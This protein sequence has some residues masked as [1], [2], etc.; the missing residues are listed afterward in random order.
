LSFTASVR[1]CRTLRVLL[2][3][4]PFQKRMTYPSSSYLEGLIKTIRNFLNA[5]SGAGS[6]IDSCSLVSGLNIVFCL[7]EMEYPFK[8]R[9]MRLDLGRSYNKLSAFDNDLLI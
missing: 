9:Q 2:G 7:P 4:T 8:Y 6:V 3:S 1:P 5:G